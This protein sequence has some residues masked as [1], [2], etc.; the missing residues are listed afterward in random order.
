MGLVSGSLSVSRFEVAARPAEPDFEAFAFEPL[1]PGTERRESIGFVPLEPEAPFRIGHD[2]WAFRIR[3]DRVRPDPTAVAERLRAYERSEAEA[4]G[5][6]HLPSRRRR[7]LKTLAEEEIARQ[8]PPRTVFVEGALDGH[9]LYLA[10]T[11]RSRLGSCLALLRGIGVEAHPKAPWLDAGVEPELLP[12][13]RFAEPGASAHGCRFLRALIEEGEAMAEPV[14][15]A[16][17]VALGDV[18]VAL[19][20][21]IHVELFRLFEQ[22]GEPLS[23][24]L[25]S[26]HGTFRFEAPTYRIAGLKAENEAMGG[27]IERLDGR[28][29]RL[30]ELFDWLDD[31]YARLGGEAAAGAAASVSA[32]VD[33]A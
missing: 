32:R 15:G 4:A 9:R 8:T 23:A 11:A 22:G 26:E 21:A 31:R 30:R 27:W 3:F 2:L 25:V 20:G 17:R 14:A 28:I 19:K 6:E 7:E 33:G 18:E 29:E 24:K 5:V 1:P 10:S 12:G 13:V 16:A